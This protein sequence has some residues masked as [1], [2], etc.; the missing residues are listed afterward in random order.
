MGLFDK[1]RNKSK[2]GKGQVKE[3]TGRTVG[4]PDL[5]ARGKNEQTGGAARQV[6]EQVKDVG[7]E[8]RKGLKQ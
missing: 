7:K 1:L 3:K 5:E 6:T 8:A 2:M 4:N